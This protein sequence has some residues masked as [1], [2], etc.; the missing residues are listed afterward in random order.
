MSATSALRFF[1]IVTVAFLL[2]GCL[3]ALNK[4]TPLSIAED[5]QGNTELI[6]EPLDMWDWNPALRSEQ[7][8]VEGEQLYFA[9]RP[10]GPLDQAWVRGGLFWH[11]K[12]DKVMMPIVVL[13]PP[14]EMQKMYLEFDGKKQFLSKP[15]DFKFTAGKRA[16]DKHLSS[17]TFALTPAQLRALVESENIVLGVWTN[18]GILRVS[19]HAVPSMDAGEWKK[20]ARYH[21]AQF[22][23]KYQQL[24]GQ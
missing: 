13:G 2:T 4:P 11:S 10:I 24:A 22:Y 20:S 23:N 3:A 8:E 12:M 19:P 7:V 21:F 9:L 14:V 17:G 5:E 1:A 6:V 16:L 18:R 15:K